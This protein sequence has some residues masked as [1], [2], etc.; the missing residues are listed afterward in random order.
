MPTSGLTGAPYC[1]LVLTQHDR[2]EPLEDGRES[3][4]PITPTCRCVSPQCQLSFRGTSRDW[5][6]DPPTSLTPQHAVRNVSLGWSLSTLTY[7]K[8]G[9]S[10]LITDGLRVLR[11]SG[12]ISLS[13]TVKI[14]DANI[15]HVPAQLPAYLLSK[16][17][18]KLLIETK[19]WQ[20]FKFKHMSVFSRK[21]DS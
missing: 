8:W 4:H 5:G 21:P 20:D 13:P 16:L 2:V 17:D 19:F 1:P 3:N 14:L 10:I 11:T 9:I 12:R 6:E 15:V 18:T 7:N